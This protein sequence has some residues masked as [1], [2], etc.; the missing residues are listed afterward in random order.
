MSMLLQ[1]VDEFSELIG[2]FYDAAL[3]AR[4]WMASL[5]KLRELF[6]ANFVSLILRPAMPDDIGLRVVA[7]GPPADW[8]NPHY[9]MSPMFQLEENRVMTVQDVMSEA[10]WRQ[11]P[12]YQH[13]CAP[14]H[15]F[16]M[17]GVDIRT[18]DAALFR[19]RICRPE[20]SEAFSAADRELCEQILPHLR[21]A[22]FF[23]TRL[24]HSES[25]RALYAQAMGRLSV[26]SIV[27]DENGHILQ[28]NSEAED[29]LKSGDG[30]KNVGGRLEAC[31][32]SDNRE[33]Q[34]VIRNT[35]AVQPKA[36]LRIPDALSV[37]RPSGKVSLGVVVQPIPALEW[38]E[39]RGRPAAMV[40]VRDAEGRTRA[41]RGVAKQLFNLTHAETALAIELA[42]GL[43]L[44]EASE[45]LGVRRNTARAHLRSIFS[46][47]GVRRQ[48]DLVRIVLNSVAPLGQTTG[49]LD[50]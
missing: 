45:S 20:E 12:Y 13:W 4:Q 39:G 11:T 23:H 15:V 8:G 34:R 22:L 18:P 40:F 16:H 32:A 29:L 43:S 42:N 10:E 38:S 14:F 1:S 26:A 28:L 35:F 49:R 2:S 5:E 33:L 31:Y 25:L 7:G 36:Q 46:K 47:T 44:D 37:T 48:T 19:L 41:V 9:T 27:L 24:E 50:D 17:L 6:R 3:D 21:R 30:L